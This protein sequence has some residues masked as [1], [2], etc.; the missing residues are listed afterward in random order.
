MKGVTPEVIA[1][2]RARASILEVVSDIV[3]LKRTGKEHKGLCPFHQ[4]KTPSFHVNPEKGIFK[5]FGCG[6]G[7]DVFAFL[8]KAKGLDFLDSVRDLAQKY[9]VPLVETVEEKQHF[10]RR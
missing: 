9:G 3:V 7:G 4:E 1:E 2:V 10:D 5:C 6:E 8:Q